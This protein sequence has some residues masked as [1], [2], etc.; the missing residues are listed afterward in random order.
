MGRIGA[1]TGK[2]QQ[3][4]DAGEALR[5]LLIYFGENRSRMKQNATR[6]P[7]GLNRR[8]NVTVHALAARA[9]A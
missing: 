7:K 3:F 2:A 1:D 8:E 5:E 9:A 6:G 4:A